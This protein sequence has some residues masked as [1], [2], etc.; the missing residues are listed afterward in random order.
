MTAE[1][2]VGAYTSRLTALD[3]LLGD[4]DF[5]LARLAADVASYDEV[6]PIP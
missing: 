1:Y 6:D 3:H 2:A 4:G 5:H